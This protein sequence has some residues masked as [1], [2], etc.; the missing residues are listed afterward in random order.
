MKHLF[1]VTAVFFLLISCSSNSDENKEKIKDDQI[2]IEDSSM[3]HDANTEKPIES[4]R[5]EKDSLK[6]PSDGKYIFDVAFA[7]YQGKS[8]GVQVAV[9]VQGDA[10]KIIYEGHGDFSAEVGEVLDEGIVMK[11]KSGVWIIGTNPD[12][13]DLDEV[14]G[15]TGGPAI[16]DFENK[17]YWMC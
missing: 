12:D 13:K 17:K 1:L 4:E 2:Q 11:H 16:I 5:I 10:I 14:G 6:M 9:V 8:M 7:E 3:G 15:C